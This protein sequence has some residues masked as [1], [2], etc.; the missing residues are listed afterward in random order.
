MGCGVTQD[1]IVMTC[2]HVCAGRVIWSTQEANEGL[3]E[4]S[5]QADGWH[6]SQSSWDRCFLDAQKLSMPVVNLHCC[7]QCWFA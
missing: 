5:T 1:L 2:N 6:Y 3:A 7:R 4:G